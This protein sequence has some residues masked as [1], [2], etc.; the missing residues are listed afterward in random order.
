MCLA[1]AADS[2]YRDGGG[3]LTA[4]YNG[5]GVD[6]A[7]TRR[8]DP[9]LAELI[10]AQ[11]VGLESVLNVG[12]GAGSYEQDNKIL[13][14]LEPSWKMISQRPAGA[15]P[16]VCGAAENLPFPDNSFDGGLALLTLHHWRDIGRGLS[17]LKR[18]VAKR[19]VIH[20]WDP[21]ATEYYWLIDDY[22]PELLAFDTARFPKIE[23]LTA[24]FR[25]AQVIEVPIPHDCTD[26]FQGAYWRR[27]EA[28]FDAR[29]KRGISSFQQISQM[30]LAKGLARLRADL[31]SGLW[32]KRYAGLLDK[33]TIDLGYRLIV[34]EI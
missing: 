4:I 8:P 29:V 16:C 31:D 27:P 24:G 6:Y 2:L 5:I 23:G 32:R 3:K 12:A 28:Y 21:E 25:S 20:T 30:A 22:I 1:C 15:A 33:E 10:R 34:A 26:G 18:V 13:V 7:A 11:I 9:R 14:A 17:E 19:L